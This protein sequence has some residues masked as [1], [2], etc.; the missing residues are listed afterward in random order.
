[1]ERISSEPQYH[2]SHEGP[3]DTPLEWSD[4]QRQLAE[5]SGLALLL[6]EGHQPPALV[7]SNN[8]SICRAIQSSPT[9]RSLCDPYCGEA[10]ARAH[11][12]QTVTHYRCHAGLHCFSAPVQIGRRSDLA[13]IGGRAFLSTADYRETLERFRSGDLKEIASQG[14]FDNVIFGL[15][16]DLASLAQRAEETAQEYHPLPSDLEAE[17]AEIKTPAT[18]APALEREIAR[19]R[20]ELHS[21]LQFNETVQNFLGRITSTDPEAT[22]LAILTNS[23]ELLHAERAS[24]LIYDEAKDELNLKAAIGLSIEVSEIEPIRVGEGIS[25]AAWLTGKPLMVTDMEV[26]GLATAPRDRRYKTRSFITYPLITNSRKVG[27]LNL[28]DKEGGGAYDEVDL[29]LL[30]I[31]APQMALALDRA[32]WQEKAIQ[33]QVMSITD[34]LT[35]LPNRRYFEER[36][37][38]EVNRSKRYHQQM[39][40]LM[41]DIDDFKMY[42]DLNGHQAGDLALQM[43]AQ[44]LRGALRSADVAARYGGEEFCILLPQT[45]L[46]EATIIAERVREKIESTDFP[47][48]KSQPLGVVTISTGV[49]TLSKTVDT[50]EQ[51]IWAADR[52]LYEAKD[53]GKNRICSYQ[54]N[55][56]VVK[57]DGRK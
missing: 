36:L 30:E 50:A 1:M 52:A 10:H 17:L 56:R 57:A 39:S 47:H 28:T 55:L 16:E 8:N 34:P 26:E 13:M 42:N 38:E 49:A 9:H 27:L 43:T 33:F 23:K 2:H 15:P 22:Y 7:V 53:E 21:H 29:N 35:G 48:A 32:E 19:L 24:L 31:V 51:V 11:T 37:T 40:F 18:E 25:G 4:R 44:A 6:V 3:R 46:G 5:D 20:K 41:I 14:L 12:A 54:E 45:S